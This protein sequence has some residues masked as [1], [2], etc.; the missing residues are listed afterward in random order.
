MHKGAIEIICPVKIHYKMIAQRWVHSSS[1]W[2]PPQSSPD[3]NLPLFA[4]A[5]SIFKDE[6][7]MDHIVM[8]ICGGNLNFQV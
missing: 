3:F 5:P 4:A 6:F 7:S 2:T 8:S 1:S